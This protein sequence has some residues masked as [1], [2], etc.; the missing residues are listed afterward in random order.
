M[1]QKTHLAVATIVIRVFGREW[2]RR[3][4]CRSHDD[5]ILE[6]ISQTAA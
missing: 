4:Q 1:V 5:A 3:A 6:R 2:F